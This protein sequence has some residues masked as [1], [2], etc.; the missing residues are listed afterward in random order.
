MYFR[1]SCKRVYD[2]SRVECSRKPFV[3]WPSVRE[4]SS[5]GS[6]CSSSS[7]ARAVAEQIFCA[8]FYVSNSLTL[9]SFLTFS[10]LSSLPFESALLALL[11]SPALLL[12]HAQSR[13]RSRL[14]AL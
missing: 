1:I 14:R 9:F 7:A 13:S 3:E 10:V 12:A 4:C 11:F 5:R 8:S 2:E 6:S